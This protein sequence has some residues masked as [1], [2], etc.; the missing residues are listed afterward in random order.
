MFER[1]MI[2]QRLAQNFGILTIWQFQ[3]GSQ[4]KVTSFG[5]DLDIFRGV[6]GLAARILMT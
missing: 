2:L 3:G 6:S 4:G 1:L 5:I